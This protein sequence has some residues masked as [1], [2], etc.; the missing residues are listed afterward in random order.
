M[1]L[2]IRRFIQQIG[3][4][5]VA[6]TGRNFF[7]V[8]RGLILSVSLFCKAFVVLFLQNFAY[9]LKLL[10][11]IEKKI[12]ISLCKLHNFWFL[13][14][15]G[16][17][18]TKRLSAK[19]LSRLAANNSVSRFWKEKDYFPSSVCFVSFIFICIF[20][21]MY[22]KYVI[23]FLDCRCYR[24][25]R[26]GSDTIQRKSSERKFGKQFHKLLKSQNSVIL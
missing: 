19:V 24:H 7:S 8:T 15:W 20:F 3:F 17:T 21:F 5:A 4:D 2:Q 26:I 11:I 9:L 16:D 22:M 13:S 1:K 25:L 18:N 23:Q 14:L 6:I 12:K 10:K